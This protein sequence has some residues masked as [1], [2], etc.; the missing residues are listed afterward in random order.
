MS[1]LLELSVGDLVI[2]LHTELA[3]KLCNNFLKLC[4]SK[5]YNFS[6]ISI[7]QQN[8]SFQ[9]GDPMAFH[10]DSIG[11]TSFDGLRTMDFSKRL[12]KA[13]FSPKLK[14]QLK[15][16]VSMACVR[17]PGASI[18]DEDWWVGSQ[19][20]VTLGDDLDYLDGRAAI[21]GQV[22]EG[23]DTLETI[24]AAFC[25]KDG[26]PMKDIRIKHTHV[27][28]DP[29]PDPEGWTEREESPVPSQ[30]QLSTVRIGAEEEV[31]ES[32]D[33]E[34]QERKRRE[35]EARAQALTLEMVGDLPFADVKPPENVLFVCKLNPVTQGKSSIPHYIRST[36]PRAFPLT[37]PMEQTKICI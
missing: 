5:Y 37:P 11:G 31:E 20:L 25:D 7:V 30:D 14:H 23:F 13:E 18:D 4:R 2:D 22:V 29:F 33:E 6:P 9:T 32:G 21:F 3:P 28:E 10:P 36:P 16:T 15:G 17:A 26:R 12:F 19:F 24:N 27:L 35:R 1:V 8:F 34:D